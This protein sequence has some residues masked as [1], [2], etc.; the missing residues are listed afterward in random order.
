MRDGLIAAAVLLAA[1]VLDGRVVG[2]ATAGGTSAALRAE[3]TE[4]EIVQRIGYWQRRT[5]HWQRVLGKR[6]SPRSSASLGTAGREYRLSV[7]RRWRLRAG[8]IWL[9]ARRPPHKRA[10][11]CIHRF[12]GHWRST[13]GGRGVRNSGGPYYGG[14]QMAL[15][16]Q[17]TYGRYLLRKKGTANR[18]SPLEQMWVAERA[19]RTRGFYPWPNT[20]RW[21]RLI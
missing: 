1:A 12:E 20:A 19:L 13:P 5:W 17:R 7:L 6:R 14:L 18:W 4:A 10:W 8:Q 11:L 21:C 15:E 2:T 3:P 9:R 16:F